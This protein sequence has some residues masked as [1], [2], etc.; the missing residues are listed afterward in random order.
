ML[1]LASAN[2]Q[3]PDPRTYLSYIPWEDLNHSSK[4][5]LEDVLLG[6]DRYPINEQV[7][8]GWVTW[9]PPRD[10]FACNHYLNVE[11]ETFAYS[12]RTGWHL[13]GHSVGGEIVFSVT[14]LEDSKVIS[15]LDRYWLTWVSQRLD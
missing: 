10:G 2:K 15:E 1:S 11:D 3:Y 9:K 4:T 7:I 5:S 12:L 14:R 6:P 8:V 13:P